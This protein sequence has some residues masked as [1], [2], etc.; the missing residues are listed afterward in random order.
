VRRTP[1]LVA[2]D[3]ALVAAVAVG[4]TGF[5]RSDKDVVLSID[6]QT[7]EVRTYADN[8]ADLLD[9]EG[10][11]VTDRDVVTPGVDE[12]LRDGST[13]DVKFA[14]QLSVTIDGEPTQIWTTA[15]T[16]DEALEQLGLR[17]ES[18]VVSVSRSERLPLT[19]FEMGIQLPDRVTV[20]ADGRR[21]TLVTAA[22]T[23]AGAL[24]EAGVR[25]G[26]RDRMDVSPQARIRDGMTISVLRVAVD[27]ARHGY[28]ITRDTVR[29]PDASM[30]E[31]NEK[32]IRVGRD[33]RGIAVYRVIKHDGVVVRRTLVERN[34]IRQPM[35]R[36]V[37]YGTKER[38]Y[39]PPS[40]SASGL[41]WGALAQ[42]ESGGNPQAVNPA[43]YYGLYQFS[44]STWYGVGGT[45]NPTDAS[46]SEQTYRA[47]VLYGRS[48]AAPWPVCGPLLYS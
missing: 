13:V 11:V 47:Q 22:A 32:V 26:G 44:L 1:W 15:V 25:V 3:V 23:V 16:V 33:G 6:G 46:S 20:L 12:D 9:E 30:Y 45:G 10:L 29:R 18:A 38:P 43:G 17:A 14:R 39:T 35:D 19:G 41:N 48:G 21:T 27:N 8:V 4:V 31:G 42:C 28:S 34:V 7:R 2:L 37:R 36:I 5:A 24:R 40:T